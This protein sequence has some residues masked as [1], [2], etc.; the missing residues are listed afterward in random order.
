VHWQALWAPA[1]GHSQP[2][3]T[4]KQRKTRVSWWKINA[5]SSGQVPGQLFCQPTAALS[6]Q[7]TSM[8]S[9]GWHSLPMRISKK[10]R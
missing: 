4:K 2:K 9:S 1:P 10:V 3:K 5:Y 7:F 8:V 6:I